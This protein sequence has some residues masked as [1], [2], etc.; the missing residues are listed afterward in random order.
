MS[1]NSSANSKGLNFFATK[2]YST[3]SK[4][5]FYNT[6]LNSNEIQQLYIDPY[7]I[8]EPAT[9]YTVVDERLKS[10]FVGSNTAAMGILGGRNL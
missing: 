2:P 7:C 6:D 10:K 5:L 3:I 8:F 4:I 1:A 9:K